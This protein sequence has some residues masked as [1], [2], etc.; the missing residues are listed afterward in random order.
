MGVDSDPGVKAG[1]VAWEGDFISG[2]WDILSI[3]PM[4]PVPV[5]SQ[6]FAQAHQPA[7]LR[8][9]VLER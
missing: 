2:C 5:Q 3:R 4:P 9:A 6:A 7:R 1:F 8:D